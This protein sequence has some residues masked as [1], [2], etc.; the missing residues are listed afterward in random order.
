MPYTDFSLEL[1]L[2]RFGL[3]LKNEEL[4][5]PDERTPLPVTPWLEQTLQRGMALALTSEKARSEFIIAPLLLAVRELTGDTIAVYSGQR[6][7]VA[8]ADGLVGECDFIIS[9]T[10][11]LPIIRAPIIS[12]V[13][14]KKGDLDLGWGQCAAQMVA[15][16]QFNKRTDPD[17]KTVYG[18]VTTGREWQFL[19]LHDKTLSFDTRLFNFD[20]S[21]FD[22]VELIL[23]TFLAMLK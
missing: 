16:L 11:P 7:D 20:N 22:N 13:E 18:C 21:N 5:A 1:V 17:R 9:A 10:Q 4:F 19:R 14:A 2:S 8:P 12:V 6:F 23:A 15:S 3:E